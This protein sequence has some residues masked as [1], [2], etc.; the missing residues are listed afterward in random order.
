[1]AAS[2]YRSFD[3][4]ELREVAVHPVLVG[5]VSVGGEVRADHFRTADIREAQADDL[6]GVLDAPL[7]GLGVLRIEVIAALDLVVE[8]GE[9]PLQ[10]LWV[11]LLL[12]QRPSQ[13]VERGLVVLGAGSRRP[14]IAVYALSASRYFLAMKKCSARRN[15]TSSANRE[16]G[17]SACQLLH[18]FHGRL[19]LPQLVIGARLLI[20]HLV[21]EGVLRILREQL[22]VQLDRLEGPAR[23]RSASMPPGSVSGATPFAGEMTSCDAARCSRSRSDTAGDAESAA[24][25]RGRNAVCAS[26]FVTA[27]AR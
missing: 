12:V 10:S 3:Q 17:Y 1:M 21:T 9:V 11:E 26:I 14:T 19:R 5:S 18:D 8:E 7:L 2:W 6:K 22:V 24:P 20:E 4:V 25:G 15:C 13:L 16:R 27:G 23:S